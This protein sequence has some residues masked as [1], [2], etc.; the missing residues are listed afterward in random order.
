MSESA[1]PRRRFL[2]SGLAAGFA[3]ALP[4]RQALAADGGTGPLTVLHLTD[5]HI[6]PEREAPVRCAG[7]L[8]KIRE[9]HPEIDLV[10]NTGDSIYAA[11]YS[12]ITRERVLEQW[13]IW[14]ETVMAG[15]KGLPILHT[16]GN[17]D[18]WW[19]GPKEDEMH[20]IPYVCKRL[21]IAKP[22]YSTQHGGW[23]ILALE[24]CRGSLDAAQREW[25]SEAIKTVPAATP[26]LVASHLPLFSLAGD[27]EGG[28]MKGAKAVIDQLASHAA[29]VVLI[30][31]HIHI[32]SSESLWNLRFHCNGALS[33]SWWEAGTQG[34]GSFKRTP[35]GYALLKLWPDGRSGWEYFPV[36][37]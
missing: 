18:L 26:L 28:N 32:Q 14:D 27:Y 36:P 33:G 5:I 21:A 35:A 22:Y 9:R 12:H 4:V 34:D 16:I 31:G 3:A 17:H 15:L 20:G 37:A 30:S 6:R 11:D 19:A 29:P 8:R 24:N 10:I 25:L 2:T 13:K 1:L 23:E 7:I